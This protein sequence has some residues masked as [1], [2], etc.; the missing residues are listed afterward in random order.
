MIGDRRDTL[1]YLLCYRQI[2]KKISSLLAY[3]HMPLLAYQNVFQKE[4]VLGFR[5][6][7]LKCPLIFFLSL[8]KV[9]SL[10][11]NYQ[12][13]SKFSDFSIHIFNYK[14]YC[15]FIR[16]YPFLQEIMLIITW[17]SSMSLIFIE[18]KQKNMHT[19]EFMNCKWWNCD[20]WICD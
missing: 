2:N 3:Q 13:W 17:V 15:I 8:W 1:Q 10:F 11:S 19:Y 9:A 18:L 7:A 12:F 5:V 4:E 16:I 6:L 20:L 14:L